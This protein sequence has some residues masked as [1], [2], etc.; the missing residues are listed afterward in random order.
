MWGSVESLPA[1][2]GTEP[3]NRRDGRSIEELLPQVS[4]CDLCFE[5]LDAP[6]LK[7]ERMLRGVLRERAGVSTAFGFERAR[8]TGG[9]EV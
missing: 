6:E 5:E 2:A 9:S 4:L 8:G 3:L 1:T 7:V